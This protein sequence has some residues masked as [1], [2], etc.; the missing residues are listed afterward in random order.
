MGVKNPIERN[1]EQIL[2]YS[3]LFNIPPNNSFVIDT[4]YLY[5]MKTIYKIDTL[6]FNNA[7]QPLQVR[8]YNKTDTL[9]SLFIN[10]YTHGFPNL[11]WNKYGEFDTIPPRHSVKINS[12]FLFQNDLKYVKT[13]NIREIDKSLFTKADYNILL[14]W[15]IF[16][17]RQSK[18]LINEIQEFV[19]RF[20]NKKIN[21]IYVNTDPLFY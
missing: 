7:V 21:V 18:I 5:D 10:C 13:L 4:M 2:K 20:P 3:E 6:A 17:N 15:S 19:K 14:F 9:L 1:N 11:K 12:L 16:M 8:F